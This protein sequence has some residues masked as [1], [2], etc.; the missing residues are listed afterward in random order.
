MRKRDVN[1][2]TKELYRRLENRLNLA[3]KKT[4]EEADEVCIKKVLPILLQKQNRQHIE[5]LTYN[6]FGFHLE[7]SFDFGEQLKA[8]G[9][10][11]EANIGHH[12]IPH[13][14]GY[15]LKYPMHLS[16]EVKRAIERIEDFRL[17]ALLGQEAEKVADIQKDIDNLT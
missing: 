16:Q 12:E 14:D 7:V 10:K 3:V 2:V 15:F 8:Q 17:N 9:L 6:G 11:F 1:L 5:R 13:S 4:R